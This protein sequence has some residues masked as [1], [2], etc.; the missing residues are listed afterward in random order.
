MVW[1]WIGFF[2]LVGLL[3]VLDLAV[4]NRRAEAHGF[5]KSLVL[6]LFWVS[7]GLA[8]SGVVYLMY[9]HHWLGARMADAQNTKHPGLDAT[10]VYLSAYLLELAL[11]VDNLFVMSLLF[12]S[13]RV[14][15][16][17]QHRVLFW[18]ILGAVV[19]RVLMLGGGAYLAN[20]FTWI[21]YVFGGYLVWSGLKL[22]KPEG[23]EA[24]DPLE[25]STA[26]R[27]LR[28]FF[29]IVEGDHDGRFLVR[30][31]GR[32]AFTTLAVCLIVIELSD[33][34][35]ALDSVPAVLAISKETFVMVTSNIL[36]ILGLRSMYSVLAGAMAKF[37]LLKYALAI[38]LVF[39]GVKMIAHDQVHIR[40]GVSLAIIAGIIATGIIASVI[41][42]RRAPA[43]PPEPPAA[44]APDGAPQAGDPAA[45]P[46]PAGRSS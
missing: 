22:F 33:V 17:Y 25:H 43:P 31:R 5:R 38:L 34:V 42:T 26:V 19:F 8:F 29:R 35:F 41:A 14:P 36:A 10:V 32:R 12:G 4:L 13:F 46:G 27:I 40:H 20:R 16:R 11:S 39:I 30:D 45:D 37:Q 18:G 1:F 3:L 24:E 21:F 7:L 15:Q 44:P 6:T 2:A 28:K 23:D 9:E